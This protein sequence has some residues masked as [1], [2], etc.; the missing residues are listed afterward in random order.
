MKIL[1]PLTYPISMSAK[2]SQP[3]GTNDIL[4]EETSLWQ[5]IEGKARRL[6]DI[7][8]YKE[9]RTPIFEETDLF[10]RSLGETSDV[11]Q[12][13]MLNLKKEGLSLRPE[14][15]A[16]V[17]RSYLENSIDKKQGL[18][19]LY[20]IGPMF[21]GERPQ[22]G[23]LRQ[24]HQI[25]VEVI[26]PSTSYPLFDV[27]VISLGVHLLDVFGVM[28][29]KLTINSLG[30][31]EDKRKLSGILREHLKKDANHLCEDCQSRFERNV[32]RILDCKKDS[33]KKIVEKLNLGDAWLSAASR[34]YFLE[35]QE[36]LKKLNISF[37]VSPYLVRGLDYYTN[38]VFEITHGALGSQDA[39]GAG[40]RY[41]SLL[42]DL[43]GAAGLGGVGFAFG[44]ERIL[45]AKK[46][47]EIKTSSMLDVFIVYAKDISDLKDPVYLAVFQLLNLLRHNNIS[48]DMSYH[49]TAMKKQLSVA[50][51]KARFA[52]IIG[53]DELNANSVTLKDMQA[54]TQEKI[55]SQNITEV[56][57]KK[58]C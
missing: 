47:E 39:L 4:P 9:I 30:I 16:S 46:T 12:K 31:P 18:A 27:E 48:A 43:G 57:K 50:S 8:G 35:V 54:R 45:L 44:L 5:E 33:C 25:G 23:R 28:G 34:D 15:T 13:Q 51:E 17:V 21:R 32:F 26:G 56:L 42:Q 10:T 58:L 53:E 3:R 40:G 1:R 11:V 14:G 55:S 36:E 24:F 37:E 49:P 19:K 7:Y 22:K 2:F 38:T 41:N 52:V 29:Y 20:Y 6:F